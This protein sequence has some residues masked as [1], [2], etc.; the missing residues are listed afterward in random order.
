M[1]VARNRQSSDKA[2]R[3]GQP[4][5]VAEKPAPAVLPAGSRLGTSSLLM[6]S[7]AGR[8]GVRSTATRLV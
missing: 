6:F 5:A 2:S 7:S 1:P 4:V 3:A 8:C